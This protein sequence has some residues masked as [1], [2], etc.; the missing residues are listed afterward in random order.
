[1]DKCM[2]SLGAFLAGLG[3]CSFI[4]LW[5]GAKRGNHLKSGGIQ[6]PW[7]YVAEYWVYGTNKGIALSILLAGVVLVGIGCFVGGVA[8][9]IFFA[10]A[11]ILLGPISFFVCAQI[12]EQM[13]NQDREYVFFNAV[14]PVGSYM[15]K[16]L[17]ARPKQLA[18][19]I[20]DDQWEDLPVV[21]SADI[22]ELQKFHVGGGLYLIPCDQQHMQLIDSLQLYPFLLNP[23]N[24]RA[25][26][27]YVKVFKSVA[28][29]G[30][31][32]PEA[33][34]S[35]APRELPTIS[36]AMDMV[37]QL[38]ETVSTEVKE[39]KEKNLEEN[40][41]SKEQKKDKK[42]KQKRRVEPPKVI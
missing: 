32:I 31:K 13:S 19:F 25:V 26:N 1:M 18:F 33:I 8:A 9:F 21:K 42:D 38:M 5:A 14:S 23:E 22:R 30:V 35:E 24:E 16:D 28:P 40:E 6:L 11:L 41:T 15:T 34:R 39:V 20:E 27:A 4:G 29:T 10:L 3:V 36:S 7:D 12:R 17:G 37:N 2:I